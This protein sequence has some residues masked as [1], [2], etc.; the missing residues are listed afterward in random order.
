[1]KHHGYYVN[2][3]LTTSGIVKNLSG[4]LN[5]S[6]V[7]DGSTHSL[8]LPAGVEVDWLPIGIECL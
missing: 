6:K 7:A 2:I 8:A 5:D 1:M 3:K 4:S